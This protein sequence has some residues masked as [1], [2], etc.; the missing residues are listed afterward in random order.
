MNPVL[1]AGAETA[2]MGVLLGWTT[3][4]FLVSMCGWWWWAFAPSRRRI[5]DEAARLPLDD[6][7][8]ASSRE[9]R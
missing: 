7:P 9:E 6:E 2:R 5:M 8:L 3:A 1:H 4:L